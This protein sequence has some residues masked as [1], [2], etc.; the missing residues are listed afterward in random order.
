MASNDLT[1]FLEKFYGKLN[2][3]EA[4][5]DHASIS[6]LSISNQT[7]S[8]ITYSSTFSAENILAVNTT[9]TNMLL[10]NLLSSNITSDTLIT[11]NHTSV[12]IFTTNITAADGRFNNVDCTNGIMINLVSTNI[13]GTGGAI[14]NFSS[15]NFTVGRMTSDNILSLNNTFTNLLLTNG[16]F[17]TFTTIGDASVANKLIVGQRIGINNTAPSVALDVSGKM[18][19]NDNINFVNDKILLTGSVGINTSLQHPNSIVLNAS[20]TQV[21]TTTAGTFYVK[22]IRN[23][24]YANVLNY[25]STTHEIVYKPY[26]YG[27]FFSDASQALSQTTGSAIYHQQTG[28]ASGI[29]MSGSPRT[30]IN[31]TQTGIYKI[32]TSILFAESAG[33][34]TTVIFWFKKNGNNI[35][36]SA[37]VVYVPGNNTLTLGYAEIIVNIDNVA[38]YIEIFGYTRSK[39]IQIA[40]SAAADG[41]PGGPGIITTVYQLN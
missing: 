37:S 30:K 21:S 11:T 41:Y 13:S 40:Y 24:Q 29:T 15:Y 36:N 27:Q 35:P 12:G 5:I 39:N 23:S 19:I 8:N 14:T 34:P 26:T 33:S 1:K 16:T 18:N 25:D 10:T 22:P 2:I 6:N 32:G 28:E 3:T 31:F 17:N 4:T 7:V 38:D 9:S 20:N